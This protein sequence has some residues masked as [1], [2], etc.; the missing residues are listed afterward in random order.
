MVVLRC[1]RLAARHRRYYQGRKPV[2]DMIHHSA[3][4]SGSIG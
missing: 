4:F 3:G 1:G 2:D